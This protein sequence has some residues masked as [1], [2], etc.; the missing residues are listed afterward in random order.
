MS[1]ENVYSRFVRATRREGVPVGVIQEAVAG[2]ERYA[3][4]YGRALRKTLRVVTI[5]EAR[6]I[7]GI[8]RRSLLDLSH[9]IDPPTRS[10]GREAEIVNRYVFRHLLRHVRSN[11]V[12]N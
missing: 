7:D 6:A 3:K 10:F 1:T 4:K 12:L 8:V 2:V 9:D 5:T 11:G